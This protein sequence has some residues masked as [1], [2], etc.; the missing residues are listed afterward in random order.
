[1]FKTYLT[2][3]Q[4]MNLFFHK[5]YFEANGVLDLFL[6]ILKL[7][8]S[9]DLMFTQKIQA[10]D[11]TKNETEGEMLDTT[12]V[13]VLATEI[14]IS[15]L[16]TKTKVHSP[17]TLL[18]QWVCSQ[19][20]LLTARLC[21]VS[22]SSYMSL[23]Q[24]SVFAKQNNVR[25]DFTG[26]FLKEDILRLSFINNLSLSKPLEANN[27]FDLFVYILDNFP[28]WNPYFELYE[29]AK[30]S[31][32]R[33]KIDMEYPIKR[34]Y[35]MIINAGS[36][37]EVKAMFEKFTFEK[38]IQVIRID[39]KMPCDKQGCEKR[40][41]VQRMIYK[42]PTVFTIALKWENNETEGE[43]FDTTSVLQ[44]EIDINTIYQ[45]KGDSAVTKYRLASMVCS[46]EDQYNCVAYENKGWVRH[47]GSEEEVIGDW[48]GVLCK[49]R[50]LHIPP[51]ILFFEN[52][53]QRDQ[54]VSK[55][56]EE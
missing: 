4:M 54:L 36:L 30:K 47:V 34:C 8:R 10:L 55:V 21:S 27:V 6:N 22:V 39:L 52:A 29:V 41:Y 32:N 33:C 35:G 42:P 56:S 9:F 16:Y 7:L 25:H 15:I 12:S 53:M 26:S 1:M 14:D 11:W 48:D 46:H 17:R 3:S 24:I 28:P 45:Y 49:F 31:C 18:S 23:W 38:I 43:I 20:G 50:N 51:E 2:A 19:G 37:R 5:T 13:L 40:N 44:T